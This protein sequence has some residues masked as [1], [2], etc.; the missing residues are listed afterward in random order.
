MAAIAYFACEA[1]TDVRC[2]CR[3]DKEPHVWVADDKASRFAAAAEAV[4]FQRSTA[5]AA[6]P[7]MYST[8]TSLSG[9]CNFFHCEVGLRAHVNTKSCRCF[10]VVASL[11]LVQHFESRTI[12]NKSRHIQSPGDV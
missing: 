3:L 7:C 4:A 11:L 2:P 9:M 1:G 12:P 8:A 6:A 10:C 5:A